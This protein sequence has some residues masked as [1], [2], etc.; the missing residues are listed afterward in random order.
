M[1]GRRTHVP[2]AARH[3]APA[4]LADM[5]TPGTSTGTGT[6]PEDPLAGRG[7]ADAR[8]RALCSQTDGVSQRTGTVVSPW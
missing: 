8:P 7:C 2:V 5:G 6:P 1:R 4:G 3:A